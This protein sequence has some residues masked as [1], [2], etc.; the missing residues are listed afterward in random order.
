M[1]HKTVIVD[2]NL[3]LLL[4]VGLTRRS[5]IEKHKRLQ[6]YEEYDFDLLKTLID[7]AAKVIVTPN[8]LTETSNLVKRIGEPART[9]IYK[10]LRLV[11]KAFEEQYVES[12]RA[13]D[14]AEFLRLG[15]AD[16]VQLDI[17]S[18]SHTLLTVDLDL[19]L[20]ASARG[21]DAVNFNYLRFQS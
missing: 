5:Y 18:E 11:V 3:L 14:R 21:V 16:A 6:E 9:Q 12:N 1:Y 10:Q 15:L 4:V 20:A 17:V 19:Y 13:V 2:A 7:S 8:T